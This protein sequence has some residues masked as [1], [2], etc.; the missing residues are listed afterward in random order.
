MRGDVRRRVG[1]SARGAGLTFLTGLVLAVLA[2]AVSLT[3]S[4]LPRTATFK[5]L[6]SAN[7]LRRADRWVSQR[8]G[9]GRR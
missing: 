8:V 6:T 9:A 2:A 4:L 3:P 1:G 5:G 7:R